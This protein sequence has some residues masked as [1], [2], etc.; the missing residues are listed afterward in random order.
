M[1]KFAT[2]L[3]R[4][5]ID[6]NQCRAASPRLSR[7]RRRLKLG[8]VLA[9]IVFILT[10]AAAIAQTEAPPVPQLEI[11]RPARPWEFVCAVGPKAGL[12]G[13]EGGTIEGWV[14]PLKIFRNLSLV[15][16]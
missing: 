2:I 13:N 3:D 1:L 15:V 11:S 12:F 5:R 16:H 6:C 8:S 14:Y 10:A 9:S 4:M 7:N